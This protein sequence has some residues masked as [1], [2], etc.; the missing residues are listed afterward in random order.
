MK[1][2]FGSVSAFMAISVLATGALIQMEPPAHAT[3][4]S[5]PAVVISKMT[6]PNSVSN[7]PATWGIYGTDLGIMW[8][9]GD[10]QI[11]TAFGDTFGS[12]WTPP[13]GNGNDWRSQVLLRSSD[14]ALSDGMSFDSAAEDYPGHAKELIPSKKIDNVEMTVI[15]TAGVAVEGR[16][17]L[18]YMSVRHW[19]IPGSWDTNYAGIAYSDDNG[20]NWVIDG[21]PVWDNPAGTSNFQMVAFEKDG[22]YVYMF[23]TPNGR[24]GSVSLARVVEGSVL[25][26]AEYRYWDGA[27][28]SANE[29]AAVTIV[30]APV[31]ELSVQKNLHSGKWLMMYMAGTD[32][33]LRNASTPAGPWSSPE[34]VVSDADFP[35][36]YGGFIHPWS[37]GSDLYF[38][39][40]EWDPY[41]AYLMKVGITSN[42][43]VT[44]PNL[45]ADPS[46]ERQTKA[47]VSSPWS[48]YGNCGIDDQIWS[49][50]GDRNA[51]VRYNSGWNDIH[52]TVAVSPHTNYTLAGWIRTSDNNKSG[53]FGVRP[54]G[55]SPI[56]EQ[57]FGALTSWTR[58]TVNFNSGNR[59]SVEL[60]GGIWPNGD[61]WIQLD[62]ISLT[63]S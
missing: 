21:G 15:P 61:T 23:G 45:V 29:S 12:T 46:F 28:W 50:T 9:N 25:D 44:N 52:Q 49:F 6:G 57:S 63:R 43:N 37:S 26:K 34:I 10:G 17:Y 16:Q 27:G 30:N 2:R 31:A 13:G 24:L 35:G 62:D 14:T 18:A 38:A 11:F 36:P 4:A 7:T 55:G 19:G 58:I 3:T 33:V 48:C 32:I 1:S 56:S 47:T 41:N 5:S 60:F 22:G 51:F 39:L 40:S 54:P 20:E 42:G 59:N 53:Y 8:D